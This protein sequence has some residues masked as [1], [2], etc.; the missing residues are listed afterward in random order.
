MNYDERLKLTYGHMLITQYNIDN[1][2]TMR[3]CI[4][5]I[6]SDHWCG[7]DSFYVEVICCH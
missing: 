6:L 7:M 3:N 2:L 1:Y 5:L 4:T